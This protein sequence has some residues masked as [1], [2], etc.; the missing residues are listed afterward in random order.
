LLVLFNTKYP[1]SADGV[2][3]L[4]SPG[5]S[6][7]VGLSSPGSS[8]FSGCYGVISGA[9]SD[10]KLVG[11][12]DSMFPICIV[13]LASSGILAVSVEPACSI[14]TLVLLIVIILG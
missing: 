8:L 1:A 5:F 12:Y 9:G 11:L 6:G 3:G 7:L 4:S 13:R 10:G 14:D 2:V